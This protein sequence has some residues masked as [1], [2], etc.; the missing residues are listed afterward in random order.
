MTADAAIR[1]VLLTFQGCKLHTLDH[2]LPPG[3][4]PIQGVPARMFT[5]TLRSQPVYS[6]SRLSEVDPAREPVRINDMDPDCRRLRDR[7]QKISLTC[8]SNIQDPI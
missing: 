3:L 7:K 4:A 1:I 5:T 8:G 2:Q 6:R